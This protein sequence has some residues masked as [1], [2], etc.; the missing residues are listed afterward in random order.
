MCLTN[1]RL[2]HR[3]MIFTVR[4]NQKY[5]MYGL[6]KY[7]RIA[8]A[9]TFMAALLGCG[10]PGLA[11]IPKGGAILAFGDSLTAGVGTTSQKSYPAVLAGLTGRRV[12]NAGVSGETTDQGVT[13]L[14]REL[15]EADPELVI[16]IEGGNDFLQNRD[17][18][19]IKA[20]LKQ[21][22]EAAK[23]R[24]VQVVLIGIPQKSLFSDSAPLYKELA[25]DFQ[26]VFDG[27]LI[28]GLLRS[29]SLKSDYVH[30]NEKGYRTMAEALY[31][32]LKE[33]GAI[34]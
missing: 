22:I 26:L 16:I 5:S 30:L 3:Q 17:A 27:T 2:S 10:S 24:G 9:M 12:I 14:P 23:S 33:N 20:N 8:A 11:P 18:A 6:N 29:P 21:M 25:D 28:A 31:A 4:S 34:N 13:R 19:T 32:L 15:D 1:C 7:L